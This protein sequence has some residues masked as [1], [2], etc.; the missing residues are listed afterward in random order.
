MTT[1]TESYLTGLLAASCPIPIA[2]VDPEQAMIV[3]A[4]G[5]PFEGQ[6]YELTLRQIET[7][8]DPPPPPTPIKSPTKGGPRKAVSRKRR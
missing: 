5:G 1:K 7:P 2:T 8:V 4:P 3:L 6:L